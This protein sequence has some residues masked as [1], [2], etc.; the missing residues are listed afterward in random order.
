MFCRDNLTIISDYLTTNAII[1]LSQCCKVYYENIMLN[2]Q[3]MKSHI[4]T[5]KKEIKQLDTIKNYKYKI[6]NLDPNGNNFIGDGDF[7]FL[8]GIYKLN[9]Q[10]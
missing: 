7:K 6:Y 10:M 3:I 8:Q 1:K 9:M 4:F 2:E 5:V